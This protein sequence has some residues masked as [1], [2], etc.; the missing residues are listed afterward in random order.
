M[1]NLYQGRTGFKIQ[2]SKFKI[3]LVT[4]NLNW[5]GLIQNSRF[6]RFKGFKIQDWDL[7]INLRFERFKRFKGFKRFKRSSFIVGFNF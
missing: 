7:R 4:I 1:V 2:D 6:K 3:R 5:W